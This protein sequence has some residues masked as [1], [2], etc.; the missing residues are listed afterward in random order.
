MARENQNTIISGSIPLNRGQQVRR[1]DDNVGNLKIGLYEIDNSIK[2]YFD[3]VIKPTVILHDQV[4]NV[5]VIYGTPERWKSAQKDGYFRDNYGKVQVPLIMYKRTNI[6][7]RYDISS[8]LDANQPH[9]FTTSQKRYTSRNAYDNF[10]VLTNAQPQ[11]ESFNVVQPNYVKISYECVIWCD[12]VEHMNKIVEAINYAAGA[13]WGEMD[14]FK[15]KSQIDS[16]SQAQ[17]VEIGEDRLVKV[18]FTLTLDGYIVPDVLQKQLKQGSQKSYNLSRLKVDFN[19]V[20][21]IGGT[22]ETEKDI[23]GSEIYQKNITVQVG[24]ID[25]NILVY[26]RTIGVAVANPTLTTQTTATFENKYIATPPAGSGLT[27]TT[28]KDFDIFINGQHVPHAYIISF[29]QSGPNVVLTIDNIGL[30]FD[31]KPTHTISVVG[32]FTS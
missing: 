24:E 16:F 17:S 31:L 15:F 18:D 11:I 19:V 25:M 28:E 23:W 8:P 10:S 9:L 3:N 13:Y 30:G 4:I 1:D 12:F 26:L 6:A 14:K 22:I 21:T 7:N 20:E 29:V 2:Y 27:T 5:P 32:K